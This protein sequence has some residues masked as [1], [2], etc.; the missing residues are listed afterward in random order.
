MSNPIQAPGNYPTSSWEPAQPAVQGPPPAPVENA[1]RAILVSA[2]LSL[3][4]VVVTLT[5]QD[6]IRA[7]LHETSPTLTAATLDATMMITVVGA[8]VFGIIFNFLYVL[9]A[10]QVRKGK[11]WARVVTI[12]FVSLG[13]FFGL[14]GLTQPAAAISRGLGLVALVLDAVI[15]VLL[16]Q[17]P[18]AEYF[19]RQR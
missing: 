5:S 7:K 14:I 10:L 18:A 6:S 2:A 8:I 19:K 11:N 13:L 1:F 16:S 4:G 17:R 9:L 15:I 12:V 3:I